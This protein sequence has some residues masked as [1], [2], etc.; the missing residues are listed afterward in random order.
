MWFYER[1]QK[2]SPHPLWI[3]IPYLV[4]AAYRLFQGDSSQLVV[5][6]IIVLLTAERKHLQSRL[7]ELL[8]LIAAIMGLLYTLFTAKLFTAYGIAGVMVF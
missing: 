3:V 2:A 1:G 8:V 7:L 4:S 6:A 5:A